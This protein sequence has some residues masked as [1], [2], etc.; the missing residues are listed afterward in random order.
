MVGGE[1]GGGAVG[2]A[3]IDDE[4]HIGADGGPAFFGGGDGGEQ[5]V[6]ESREEIG[7]GVDAEDEAGGMGG[8]VVEDDGVGGGAAEDLG[9]KVLFGFVDD[10]LAVA[11]RLDGQGID[12]DGFALAD[13]VAPGVEHGVLEDVVLQFRD[14]ELAGDMFEEDIAEEVFDDGGVEV[15]DGHEGPFEGSVAEVVLVGFGGFGG[16]GLGA[17]FFDEEVGDLVVALGEAVE[18]EEFHDIYDLRFTIFLVS[19]HN[20]VPIQI[21]I[22]ISG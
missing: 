13:A 3:V 12:V 9:G 1:G 18:G 11:D 8:G 16:V 19:R 14:G 4:V 5:V 6:F 22:G 21:A 17:V 15:V 20:P 7:A 2:G 10:E